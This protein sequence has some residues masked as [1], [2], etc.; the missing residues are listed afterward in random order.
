MVALVEGQ[1]HIMYGPGDKHY[2]W[3]PKKQELQTLGVIKYD[4]EYAKMIHVE[5]QNKLI[6]LGGLG[7]TDNWPLR[8]NRITEYS[9]ANNTWGLL[10]DKDGETVVLPLGLYGFGCVLTKDERYI[11]IFGGTSGREGGEEDG[12]YYLDLLTMK[13]TECV[14]KCP[15]N[16][17]Y[18]AVLDGMEDVHIFSRY[19]LDDFAESGHWKI[20]IKQIIEGYGYDFVCAYLKQMCD[21]MILTLNVDIIQLI[22]KWY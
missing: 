20:R 1:L 16:N 5:S 8:S 3:D 22:Y 11:V 18:V 9:I 7:D 10:A 17:N 15:S 2:K 19:Y 4:I 6:L 21:K 14:L 12:I 13:W